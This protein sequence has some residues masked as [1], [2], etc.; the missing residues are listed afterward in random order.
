M[1]P[2]PCRAHCSWNRFNARRSLDTLRQKILKDRLLSRDDLDLLFEVIGRQSSGNR[3][4][5]AE[6]PRT[7]SAWRDPRFDRL[8]VDHGYVHFDQCVLG[9]FHPANGKLLKKPTL[10][11][12]TRKS[13]AQHTCQFRCSHE[14]CQHGRI[15]G[16]FQ[17]RSVSSWPEDYEP[18]LRHALIKG[19]GR[20]QSAFAAEDLDTDGDVSSE[21]IPCPYR[22][23]LHCKEL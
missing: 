10:V 2:F 4:T 1:A 22:N 23:V 3:H 17:G 16:T 13:L 18:P 11:F 12:I 14:G 15:E 9:L 6:N 21:V 20:K 7:S 5:H 19:F 8:S